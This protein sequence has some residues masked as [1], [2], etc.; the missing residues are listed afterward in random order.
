MQQDQK[1]YADGL[2][3]ARSDMA[4]WDQMWR[5]GDVAWVRRGVAISDV[6]C[7]RIGRGV[8]SYGT[9]RVVGSDMVCSWIGRG[10]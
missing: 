4:W 3:V 7:G 6:E 2:D 1:R 8:W 5:V 10:V 9:W